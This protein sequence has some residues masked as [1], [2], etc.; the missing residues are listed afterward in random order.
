[1]ER[2]S[3][4]NTNVTTWRDLISELTAEQIAELEHC[5]QNRIPP[6]LDTDRHRLNAAHAMIRRN[7]AQ[8]QFSHIEPP[9]DCPGEIGDWYQW[10]DNTFSR[11]YSAWVREVGS[12]GVEV[13]GTQF[14]D[15][16]VMR[17]IFVGGMD[18]MTVG[19]VRRLAAAL[20]DAADVI[21]KIEKT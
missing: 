1:M 9:A 5:E 8:Q 13:M 20:L 21:E 17:E 4:M 10:N 12:T 7:R 11:A 19:K 16:R 18:G 15:G 14:S 3:T 2:L 6:G